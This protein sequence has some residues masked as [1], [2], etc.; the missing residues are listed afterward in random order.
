MRSQKARNAIKTAI[1]TENAME[2][3]VEATGTRSGT[4]VKIEDTVGGVRCADSKLK[5]L[6]AEANVFDW[7]EKRA[8][9]DDWN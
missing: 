7:G 5:I 3:T 8:D 4:V 9:K 6:A 1:E 2:A